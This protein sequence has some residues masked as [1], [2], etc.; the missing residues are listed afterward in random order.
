ML[1]MDRATNKPAHERYSCES[2]APWYSGDNGSWVRDQ[3]QAQ[4]SSILET[5]FGYHLLQIGPLR[6]Q[7]LFE[8]SRINHR[9]YATPTLGTLTSMVCEFD[10]IPLESDSVD[11]V[12]CDH[13]VEYCSN[14]HQAVRE[15]QRVLAPQG[16]LIVIGFNPYSF[17]GAIQRTASRFNR[18]PWV[19]CQPVSKPRLVDWLH[20]VGCEIQQARYLHKLPTAGRGRL[21]NGLRR[22]ERFINRYNLPSG[23]VY[24]LHAL[25][26]VSG[27]NRQRLVQTP[28][29]RLIGLGVSRPAPTP[30]AAPS[31]PLSDRAGHRRNVAA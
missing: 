30:S 2:L 13:A 5:A 17:N 31:V 15:M 22:T 14:P 16:H 7:P 9:L 26:Q 4:V 23:G 11:V 25:K 29:R 24:M 1:N 19:N 10:E 3:L 27:A 21:L 28:R 6:D 18:G 8:D 12:I 20:L